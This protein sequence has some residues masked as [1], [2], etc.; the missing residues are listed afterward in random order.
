MSCSRVTHNDAFTMYMWNKLYR[1]A[2]FA[3]RTEK[4]HEINLIRSDQLVVWIRHHCSKCPRFLRPKHFLTQ[5]SPGIEMKHPRHYFYW[6]LCPVTPM[7][8]D[9]YISAAGVLDSRT[10]VYIIALR[11]WVS[12]ICQGKCQLGKFSVKL[13]RAIVYKTLNETSNIFEHL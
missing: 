8:T 9:D 13:H 5:F 3:S 7:I 10:F 1:R 6:L 2:V 11:R 4:M 12:C